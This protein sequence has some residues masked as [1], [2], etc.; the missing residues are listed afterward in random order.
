VA[1]VATSW[2][3]GGITFE[4]VPDG[5][6]RV[7]AAA[8]GY[9]GATQDVVVSGGTVTTVEIRLQPL[10]ARLEGRVTHAHSGA[11]VAGA[12]V[13]LGPQRTVT[14]ADGRYTLPDLQPGTYPLSVQVEGYETHRAEVVIQSGKLETRD[15]ALAPLRGTVRVRVVDAVTGEPIAG[16]DVRCEAQVEPEAPCAD[17]A[18]L[19]P[20]KRSRVYGAVRKRVADLRPADAWQQDGLHFFVFT[21]RPPDGAPGTG[22]AGA[23]GAGAPAEGPLAIFA[24]RPEAREPVSAVVVTPSAEG[25]ADPEITDLRQPAPAAPETA[26]PPP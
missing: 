21:L 17:Y 9:G 4:A 18:L 26:S 24:M 14:D 5:A 11:P 22:G 20:L 23:G 8:A 10:L 16:A 19:V 25:G 7:A 13:A 6:Y 2:A 1:L 12:A 3:D 15:V